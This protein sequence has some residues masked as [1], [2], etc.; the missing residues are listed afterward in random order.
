MEGTEIPPS[1]R[2]T[3][4]ASSLA[5]EWSHDVCRLLLKWFKLSPFKSS[6]EAGKNKSTTGKSIGMATQMHFT[7]FVVFVVSVPCSWLLENVLVYKNY[8]L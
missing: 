8:V 4:E 3:G 5:V 1:I 6:K 7:S 2:V